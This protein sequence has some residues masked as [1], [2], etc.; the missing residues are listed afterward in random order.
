MP[1]EAVK[2]SDCEFSVL[3]VLSSSFATLCGEK[4]IVDSWYHC[5]VWEVVDPTKTLGCPPRGLLA[6][7][8]A[9]P[10][11]IN[12]KV[13]SELTRHIC[14]HPFLSRK[15]WTMFSRNPPTNWHTSPGI[16]IN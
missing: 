8:L 2:V 16:L 1:K 3:S 10:D 15:N 14:D 4:T 11:V 9:E 5:E 12:A 7:I 6:Q 13:F